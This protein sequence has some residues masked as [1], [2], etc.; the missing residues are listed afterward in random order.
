MLDNL[1]ANYK[2]VLY[3]LAEIAASTLELVGILTIIIG[4]TRALLHLASNLLKKGRFHVAMDLGKALSLALEFKMGAEII[5][6]VVIHTLEELA[7]L[8]VVIL[9]RAL[10]AVIIHWEIRTKEKEKSMDNHGSREK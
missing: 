8:G 9:L 4:S 5:K 10:M 2:D 7:I 3:A 1:I 6:T